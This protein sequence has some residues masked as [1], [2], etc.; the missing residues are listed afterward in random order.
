MAIIYTYP[1]KTTPNA[2]DL[3]LISDS[4]DSNKTKQVKI[5]SLPGGSGSGVSSVTSAN[6]AITVADAS[7]TPVL[8]SVAYSG[9]ANIGHVP[10]GSGSS[11]TVY[12]DGTGNWSTP[13]GSS[14][15]MTSTTEGIAKI[16]SDTTQ[17]TVAN[18][19]SST[20]SRTYGVQLNSSNQLVV[21]VPWT[22]GSSGSL[23][24]V[25]L[26]MPS[27]FTVG[28]SPLTADGTI[29]VTINGGSSSTY[30]RGDGSWGT[31]TG[32]TYNVMGSG[33]SY[34]AGLVLAG[35]AT[36]GSQFLRKDGTWQTVSSSAN[37]IYSAD[38]TIGANRTVGIEANNLY[39][40][41]GNAGGGV[42]IGATTRTSSNPVLE[43]VGGGVIE[44]LVNA[45]SGSPEIG[46]AVAGAQ[47]GGIRTNNTALELLSGGTTVGLTL[48]ASSNAVFA[49]NISKASAL[50][51]GTSSGNSDITLDPNQSG[52]GVVVL[53][54]GAGRGAGQIKFNCDQNSHGVTI[55][56]PAH[57]AT[58][59]YTLTLPTTDGNANEYLKTDGDGALSWADPSPKLGFTPLS[60]YEATGLI[61]SSSS[62][63]FSIVR[64]SVC[65]TD[66]TIDKVD[67]FRLSGTAAVSIAVYTGTLS[68]GTG[69]LRLSGQTQSGS[70]NS[71]TTL[72]F[73]SPYTF[74]AGDDIIILVSLNYGGGNY[75]Q[76]L[77][78]TS[79]YS[80]VALGRRNAVYYASP[81]QTYQEIESSFEE[82]YGGAAAL[83]FYDA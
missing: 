77:G 83:H 79:L 43:V 6:T 59:D 53:T 34:L 67:F 2:N 13:G 70:A 18:T 62:A 15:T 8:T 31:P 19:V 57:S 39:F 73:S 61:G 11:A 30:Y 22:G 66:C 69:V 29:D 23:N 64:Q 51:I 44:L 46:F 75:A 33:N 49:G 10:T 74:T 63:A 27:G 28:S 7:T 5:S 42:V 24:S 68:A 48:D 4:Q 16:F 21:N 65:E 38:G 60:I 35:N 80:H 41:P 32:T 78:S 3:I 20:A 1:V 25:G 81:P 9:G 76:V 36:H 37:N 40:N 52:S 71:I 14:S 26:T 54:G 56:G 17:S 58:A 55:K 45:T 12:L 72:T 47:K 82:A 50:T